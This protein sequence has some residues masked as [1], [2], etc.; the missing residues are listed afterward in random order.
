[1]TKNKMRSHVMLANYIA[2]VE[3]CK[4]PFM[5]STIVGFKGLVLVV[6]DVK[7]ANFE[8][9]QGL[10]FLQA[11]YVKI[12]LVGR[13]RVILVFVPNLD[14]RRQSLHLRSQL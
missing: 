6:K 12:F 4:G 2:L 9:R 10:C 1:M 11:L 5:S 7:T 8:I 13:D 3:S 14:F